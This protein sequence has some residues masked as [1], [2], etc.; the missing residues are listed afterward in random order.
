MID[1]ISIDLIIMMVKLKQCS[2]KYIYIDRF[3]N[4][5]MNHSFNKNFSIER[6]NKKDDILNFFYSK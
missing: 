3:K 1:L 6:K 2:I 5:I 4:T